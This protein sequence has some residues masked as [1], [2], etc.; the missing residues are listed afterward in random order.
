MRLVNHAATSALARDAD[1]ASAVGARRIDLMIDDRVGRVADAIARAPQPRRHFGFLF[2]ARGAGAQSLI[3][4]PDHAQRFGEER[5]VGAHHAADLDDFVAMIDQRKIE[6]D[7]VLP[8]QFARVF[9]RED[10]TL[11]R[12]ELGMIGEK[13]LDLIEIVVRDHQV[14]VKKNQ[15]IATR[16]L[17]RE[18][19]HAAFARTRVVNVG[20]DH[21]GVGERK[22]RGVP[23]SA[24]MSSAPAGR[25]C[26]LSDA[27]RRA[28]ESGRARVAMMIDS[29]TRIYFTHS[30]HDVLV[31]QAI[32]AGHQAKQLAIDFSLLGI[33]DAG[34]LEKTRERRDRQVHQR[35]ED[36]GLELA[37]AAPERV[38][39]EPEPMR[40]PMEIVEA[41]HVPVAPVLDAI[42][43]GQ[44]RAAA[45]VEST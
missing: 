38:E 13:S 33:L 42:M 32:G 9:A 2:V 43:I 27:S 6:V 29:F 44:G 30:H 35:G 23:F 8:G 22:R 34:S 5:H 25:N 28:S 26:G 39:M 40:H 36:P 1:E 7:P 14:V 37:L 24:T 10:A 19:L 21:V 18:I 45:L 31:H 15:D 4:R 20:G 41:H 11:H 17:D 12:G 16:A 3:K